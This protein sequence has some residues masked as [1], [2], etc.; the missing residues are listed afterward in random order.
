MKKGKKRLVMNFQKAWCLSVFKEA[1]HWI[2][3]R[4]G[5]AM[6]MNP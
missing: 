2:P 4:K 3:G 1:Y 5:I 6:V